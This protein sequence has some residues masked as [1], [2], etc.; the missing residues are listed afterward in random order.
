[1]PFNRIKLH[2]SFLKRVGHIEK[3]NKPGPLSPSISG[4]LAEKK[5]I[6]GYSIASEYTVYFHLYFSEV[7]LE[8]GPFLQ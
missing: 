6:W 4:L 8:E 2:V 7:F 1:M 3:A 5:D